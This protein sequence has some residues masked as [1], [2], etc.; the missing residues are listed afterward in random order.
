MVELAT[1]ALL[2]KHVQ[3]VAQCVYLYLVNDFASKCIHEQVA[4]FISRYTAL[5]HV[6]E[7][8]LDRKSVV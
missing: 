1:Q 5:L 8:I 6:E 3:P 7:C 4:R 2:D